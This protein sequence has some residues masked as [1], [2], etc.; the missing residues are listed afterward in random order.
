MRRKDREV[1]DFS[2]I[3][4]LVKNCHVI[5]IALFDEEYPYIVP[6]NFGNIWEGE[7]LKLYVHGARQG[8]KINLINANSAVA[9]EMDDKHELIETGD[10]AE[11]YSYA[12]QSLIGFGHAQIITDLKQK[13]RALNALME[14]ETGRSLPDFNPIPERIIKA[15]SIIE[16]IL[17]RYTMKAHEMP[18]M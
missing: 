17:D 12:Y 9:I 5:R 16:I 8:K 10:V 18:K 2:Q 1:S 4:Q 11:D 6:V 14:H 7:Q 3:Q 15:T 13:T